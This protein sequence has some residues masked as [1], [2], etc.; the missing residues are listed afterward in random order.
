MTT[1]NERLGEGGGYAKRHSP[2]TPAGDGDGLRSGD[3]AA[4][5]SAPFAVA[6]AHHSCCARTRRGR[7]AVRATQFTVRCSRR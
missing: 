1:A 3:V 6:S 7:A 2:L 5:S 4:Y